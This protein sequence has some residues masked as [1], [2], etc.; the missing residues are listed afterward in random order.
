MI[1]TVVIDDEKDARVNTMGLLNL[2]CPNLKVLGTASGVEEGILLIK[3]TTPDL[4][5][6]DIDMPDGTGF[7]LL[8]QLMPVEFSVI[9][10]TAYAQHALKAIKFNALDFLVKPLDPEDLLLAIN[11]LNGHQNEKLKIQKLESLL[12]DIDTAHTPS[13]A[14]GTSEAVHFVKANQIIRVESDS[15][16]SIFYLEGSQKVMVS[17]PLKHYSELLCEHGFFRPLHGE[18]LCVAVST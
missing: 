5:L 2:H 13:L 6:L 15:N 4:V 18:V 9:F 12:K 7:D 11:K 3:E 16:Y 8:R 17:Q 14:L 1:N 10:I